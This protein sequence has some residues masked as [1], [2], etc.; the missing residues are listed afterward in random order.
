MARN[1]PIFYRDLDIKDKLYQSLEKQTV[2]NIIP[3]VCA[4]FTSVEKSVIFRSFNPYIQGILDFLREIT[5][6][7]NISDTAKVFVD[8][9]FSDL[10]IRERD[11][12]RFGYLEKRKKG[13]IESSRMYFDAL[14]HYIK[15]ESN[16]LE[17]IDNNLLDE[18]K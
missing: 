12:I 17:V 4:I 18:I 3:I 5:N 11:I 15:L 6:E 7:G 1:K 13:A 14:P 10:K 16:L 8:V 9:L 2:G